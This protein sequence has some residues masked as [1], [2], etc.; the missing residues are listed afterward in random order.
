MKALQVVL[1]S[2]EQIEKEFVLN[3]ITILL[4]GN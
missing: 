4:N 3:E 2:T 1:S